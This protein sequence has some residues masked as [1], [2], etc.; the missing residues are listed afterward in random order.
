MDEYKKKQH[1]Y[2]YVNYRDHDEKF[3]SPE[4]MK[5]LIEICQKQTKKE[6][7]ENIVGISSYNSKISV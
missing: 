4:T 2:Y 7:Q 3:I 5:F 6:F 1:I